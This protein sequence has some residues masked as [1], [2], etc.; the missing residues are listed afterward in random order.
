M[1]AGQAVALQKERLC[2]SEIGKRLGLTPQQVCRLWS[3]MG[4]DPFEYHA[5][6]LVAQARAG[7]TYTAAL[8]HCGLSRGGTN[9]GR[10]RILLEERGIP[11]RHYTIK[12]RPQGKPRRCL[13]CTII[14]EPE[15]HELCHVCRNVQ[16]G[17]SWLG[18][19][20]LPAQE[21]EPIS[22]REAFRYA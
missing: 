4:Y 12:P 11:V 21:P 2:S 5:D 3:A 18:R 9:I 20:P 22:L 10:L 13:S 19:L 14:L 17:G 16:N 6:E 7:A 15:E 1:L 8:E